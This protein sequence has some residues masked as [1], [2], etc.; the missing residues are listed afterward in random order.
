MRMR[1]KRNLDERIAAC[2][3]LIQA[4]LS[5]KNMLLADKIDHRI[6]FAAVFGNDHPVHLEIGCGKGGFIMEMARR[7]PELNFVAIEMISNVLVEPCE[8]SLAEGLSNIVYLNTRAEC[9]KSYIPP[10]SVEKIYLNFSTPL[11]KKGYEKQRLTHPRFLSIYR[12][13][14]KEGGVVS[15]KTDDRFFFAYSLEQFNGE[16]WGLKH[17]STDLHA[18]NDPEN[19]VTEHE[20]R[21]SDQGLPIFYLEAFIR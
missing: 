8:K 3:N 4:D 19:I 18:D 15:Q 7:H 11:P 9:L 20:K 2:T 5:E 10:R 1:R 21:F 12:E 17:I 14:L 13:L 6:D 16:N